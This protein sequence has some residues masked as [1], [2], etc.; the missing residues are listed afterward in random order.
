MS[1]IKNLIE[2]KLIDLSHILYMEKIRLHKDGRYE[3]TVPPYYSQLADARDEMID[4]NYG[5]IK[6]DEARKRF[7][8]TNLGEFSRWGWRSCGMVG[9]K[10]AVEAFTSSRDLT[11]MDFVNEGIHINGYDHSNDRG[12]YHRALAEVAIAHGIGATVKRFV[13]SAE[14]S[15]NVIDGALMLCS[16][17]SE[18]GGHLVLVYG[19]EVKA[20][21]VSK[22]IMHDPYTYQH[23]GGKSV[24]VLI[25]DFDMSFKHKGIKLYEQN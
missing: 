25:D 9:V 6:D 8:A 16:V 23:T 12:W 19:V 13:S 5:L 22:L 24:E 18:S 17:K 11:I 14:V 4:G 21:K 1:R 15:S 3:S 7:G 20:G 2:D 10:M